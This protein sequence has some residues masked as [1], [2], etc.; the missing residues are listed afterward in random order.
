MPD[1][2]L[3]SVEVVKGSTRHRGF[4]MHR[5][6]IG[7]VGLFL[8]WGC[9]ALGEQDDNGGCPGDLYPRAANSSYILPYAVDES[10]PTGLTNC[11]GTFHAFGQPDQYAFDFDM[12]EG[13]PFVAARGGT[14][15]SVVEHALSSGGGVGNY[16]VIDH[17]DGTYALYLHAPQNGISVEVGAKVEQGDVLGIVGRSGLAGYPHIHFIVVKDSPNYP[18]TGLPIA[19][20]NASPQHNILRAYTRYKAANY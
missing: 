11:S 14:V 5:V 4:I 20:K 1:S 9:T 7:V 10:H 6:G 18:Y 19:F 16:V 15:F 8:V 12:P 3:A 2:S 13:A 17:G